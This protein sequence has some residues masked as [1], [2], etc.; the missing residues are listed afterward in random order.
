MNRFLGFLAIFL[1]L[2]QFPAF[3]QNKKNSVKLN[4]SGYST[5]YDTVL[6]YP[7]LVE[8]WATRARLDCPMTRIPRNDRF[9]P[10]PKLPKNTDLAASYKG[11]GLDRGH[12]CPAADNQCDSILQVECFY[13]SNM[14]PQYHSLNAG[15]W[16]TL[17][18]RTRDLAIEYDSVKVWCGSMGSERKI[19]KVSIPTRCWKVIFVKKTKQWEA[20]FFV[21]SKN[22]EATLEKLK[23]TVKQVEA[24][25][26]FKFKP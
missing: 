22:Q 2:A 9:A 1:A 21:N 4:H 17:E 8:W 24:E 25:T 11:S 20:Y 7:V 15:V 14:A 19:G 23:V 6:N 13:F 18:T 16:K 10:D 12:M 26:G 3:G 5:N